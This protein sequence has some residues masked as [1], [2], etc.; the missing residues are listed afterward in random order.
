[1]DPLFSCARLSGNETLF[2]TL[3]QGQSPLGQERLHDVL[4]ETRPVDRHRPDRAVS[5]ETREE[6]MQPLLAE[7]RLVLREREEERL[8]TRPALAQKER[9]MI[10]ALHHLWPAR[11]RLGWG[12]LEMSTSRIHRA[13]LASSSHASASGSGDFS[14][15]R[16]H[17]AIESREEAWVA[18]IACA[19]DTP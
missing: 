10:C 8:V 2:F 5:G 14:G 3:A 6:R 15:R 16:P 13:S 11:A 9:I 4:P 18:R 17:Q 19:S 1:M 12:S 7:G